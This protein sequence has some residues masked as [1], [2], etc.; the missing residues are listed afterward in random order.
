MIHYGGAQGVKNDESMIS[1]NRKA[2]PYT[3]R[4]EVATLNPNGAWYV[5]DEESNNTDC[6]ASAAGPSLAEK[7]ANR[8][9]PNR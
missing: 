8:S 2:R 1:L 3:Y 5:V 9:I 7:Q 4:T 6:A